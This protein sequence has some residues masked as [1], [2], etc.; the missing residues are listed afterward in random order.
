MYAMKIQYRATSKDGKTSQGVLEAKDVN[1]AV[2]FLRSKGLLPLSVREITKQGL[3]FSNL[4]QGSST[5]DLVLFTR[6]LSSIL[7]SGLTLMQALNIL[8]EQVQNS[9]MKQIVDSLIAD[10]QEGKTFADA[11]SKY[12]KVFNPIYI[13]LIR[14]AE[15]SGFLDKVLLRLADNLEKQQKLKS[16]IKSALAY[17]VIVIIL[18]VVVM[19]VMMI[20]VIPQL[21]VLYQNLNIP[22]PFTTQVM[23]NV[24]NF[25]I[26]FW[27]LVLGAVILMGV[28]YTRWVRTESGKLITDSFMLRLPVFGVLIKKTIMAEFSRTFGLLVGAGTLV[29]QSLNESADTAGNVI[30]KSA[31]QEVAKRVEKGV[32]IGDAMAAFD[33]FPP[34]LVQMVKI[35]EQTGKLDDS[36]LRVSEYFEREVDGTVKNLTTAMEPFIMI[37]LGIGVSFLIISI[38]TPIY[39]LT[40][41]IQ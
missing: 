40:S 36:L 23:V 3:S 2:G 34:I 9:Q 6:Q 8:K 17:P 19:F 30:Y 13:S 4:F 39:N 24:S 14:A 15:S 37:V 33:I 1:E 22:L 29:V 21:T 10:V 31:I 32:S 28:A 5:Q 41:N 26:S 18:M 11:I 35:G 27:P 25:V 7:S 16:T 12:P 38:I 20:F